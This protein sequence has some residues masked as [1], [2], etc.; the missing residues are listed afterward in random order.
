[1]V[2]SLL[3]FF[4]YF[5]PLY[6]LNLAK[7][8]V[9]R[10]SD[11]IYIFG[12]GPSLTNYDFT[13]VQNN[14]N[15]VD[16][17]CYNRSIE[18]VRDHS[19][20]FGKVFSLVYGSRQNLEIK[21]DGTVRVRLIG[22]FRDFILKPSFLLDAQIWFFLKIRLG[23]KGIYE[24]TDPDFLPDVG[25]N[26]LVHSGQGSGI[27]LCV[28]IAYALGYKRIILVGVDFSTQP[29]RS[30]FQNFGDAEL[31]EKQ[32]RYSEERKLKMINYAT[33]LKAKLDRLGV[34]FELRNSR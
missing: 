4:I 13:E 15:S 22:C 7:K 24:K 29:G 26:F 25:C 31:V 18:Y 10:E 17:F 30:H 3:N 8:K 27:F 34:K 12:S 23:L 33:H 1:M 6:I 9:V 2:N 5:F 16:A 11:C 28:Q 21:E 14:E 32:L 19:D 20:V